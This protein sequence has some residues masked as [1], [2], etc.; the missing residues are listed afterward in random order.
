M[1]L[2]S[3][4]SSTWPNLEM[5]LFSIVY[6]YMWRMFRFD[7]LHFEKGL[8]SVTRKQKYLKHETHP[9]FLRACFAIH[10]RFPGK[11]RGCLED[12]TGPIRS[13]KR[14]EMKDGVLKRATVKKKKPKS[15]P[16]NSSFD[17]TPS[18]SSCSILSEQRRRTQIVKWAVA[19]FSTLFEQNK[20]SPD[21]PTFHVRAV[22]PR[23]ACLRSLP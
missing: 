13:K 19:K 20:R 2:S 5:R 21:Q 12:S 4:P 9:H 1:K 14:P 15:L 6:T 18:A 11:V 8:F 16:T 3:R 22:V 17:S 23:L 10:W 7:F